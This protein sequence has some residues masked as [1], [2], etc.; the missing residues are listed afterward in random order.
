M[1]AAL[2]RL[3]EG[4]DMLLREVLALRSD[5]RV[6]P[7]SASPGC[8]LGPTTQ[9]CLLTKCTGKS[10]LACRLRRPVGPAPILSMLR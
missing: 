6:G 9:N 2:E 4:Q 8:C 10:K 1:A 5:L 7:T 3:A